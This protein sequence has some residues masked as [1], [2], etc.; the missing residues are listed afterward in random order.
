MPIGLSDRAL[1]LVQRHARAL[2]VDQRD[3]FLRDVAARLASE[4]SDDAVVQA[5]NVV[6]DRRRAVSGR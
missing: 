4:P 3:K 1:S 5:L 6:M 2:P